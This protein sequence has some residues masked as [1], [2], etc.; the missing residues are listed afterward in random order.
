MAKV[1]EMYSHAPLGANSTEYPSLVLLYT[2]AA[3]RYCNFLFSIWSATGWGPMA[4]LGMMTSGLPPTFKDKVTPAHR[5]RMTSM[6]TITRTQIA[7]VAAMAHGPW[8]VHLQPHDRI[9]VL[10]TLATIYSCLG[11]V[12][13]EVYVLREVL[14]VVMDLIVSARDEMREGLT[15]AISPGGAPGTAPAQISVREH[16]F[17]DGNESIVRLVRHICAVYGIDLGAVK[18]LGK[19]PLPATNGVDGEEKREGDFDGDGDADADEMD[20][21]KPSR[22]GWAE[23]QVGVVREA[24]AIAEAL[25]GEIIFRTISHADKFSQIILQSLNSPYQHYGHCTFISL[26]RSSNTYIIP[27]SEP[28]RSQG[29]EEKNPESSFGVPGRSSV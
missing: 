20:I 21:T 22:F 10:S 2:D 23:L 18:L 15:S 25:P 4:F 24:V 6:T 28:F 8:L 11:F 5:W 19:D 16:E 9:R 12:R 17:G 7:N 26:L 1:L 14:S 13:K 27:H 29:D 3:L